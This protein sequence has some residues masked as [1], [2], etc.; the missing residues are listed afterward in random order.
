MTR[1]FVLA[2]KRSEGRLLEPTYETSG[3][4]EAGAQRL[5]WE[6]KYRAEGKDVE[7]VVLTAPTVE[8]L[9]KT[10]ARYFKTASELTG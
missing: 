3:L 9:K 1:Y 8:D 7:V 6:L 5:S 4:A 2:Y 10:H